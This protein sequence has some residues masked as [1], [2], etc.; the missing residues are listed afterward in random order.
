MK[1][2]LWLFLAFFLIRASQIRAQTNRY[3]LGDT[4]FVWASS[5]NIRAS[6]DAKAPIIGK[7]PY[8]A[9]VQIADSAIGK[10]AYRYKALESI[11][12]YD[13]TKSKP[14][15]LSGFWVNVHCDNKTG[16]IFDGYLSRLPTFSSY[17]GKMRD[18][19]GWATKDLNLIP[20]AYKFKKEE[21]SG[22]TYSS[23]QS[24]VSVEIG[25]SEKGGFES[26]SIRGVSMQEALML[27]IQ[28]FE[29]EYLIDIY[30]GQYQFHTLIGEPACEIYV[31]HK[32]DKI[33]IFVS[34]HC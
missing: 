11:V 14:F 16:Y 29:A 34:C 5:L 6:P 28:I 17:N 22:I 13:G 20:H 27:A 23:K 12:L 10:V 32:K 8:G 24:T 1:I 7:I 21:S 31:S 33:V 2:I 9:Q 15:Y 30:D 18:V 4:L 3:V 19:M 26:I 25:N